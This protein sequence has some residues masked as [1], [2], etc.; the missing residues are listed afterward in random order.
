M[1]VNGIKYDIVLKKLKAGA[2]KRYTQP[3]TEKGVIGAAAFHDCS[4]YW[5]LNENYYI[6]FKVKDKYIN[7][8]LV[9]INPKKKTQDVAKW[10]F[11]NFA[12]YGV[13]DIDLKDIKKTKKKKKKNDIKGVTNHN[14]RRLKAFFAAHWNDMIGDGDLNKS[15]KRIELVLHQRKIVQTSTEFK[16]NGEFIEPIYEN[17]PRIKREPN[18]YGNYGLS[19][20]LRSGSNTNTNNSNLRSKIRKRKRKRDQCQYSQNLNV[21]R[22]HRRITNNCINSYSSSPRKRQRLQSVVKNEDISSESSDDDDDIDLDI[23]SSSN[24]NSNCNSMS[25]IPPSI[26]PMMNIAMPQT[27]NPTVYSNPSFLNGLTQAIPWDELKRLRVE[28]KTLAVKNNDLERANCKL[29]QDLNKLS[30]NYQNLESEMFNNKHVQSQTEQKV[31]KMVD[32]KIEKD[33]QNYDLE[34]KYQVLQEENNR[35]QKELHRKRNLEIELKKKQK[36]LNDMEQHI[37]KSIEDSL[38][39]ALKGNVNGKVIDLITGSTLSAGP[40]NSYLLKKEDEDIIKLKQ[41]NDALRE[42][43]KSMIHDKERMDAYYRNQYI[44]LYNSLCNKFIQDI[45]NQFGQIKGEIDR[46]KQENADLQFQRDFWYSIIG[47]CNPKMIELLMS[48]HDIVANNGNDTNTIIN[49]INNHINNNNENFS[50]TNSQN[51]LLTNSSPQQTQLFDIM[52]VGKE[53]INN[54]NT[55]NGH[56]QNETQM[57][58]N[59]VEN[60]KDNNKLTPIPANSMTMNNG[61]FPIQAPLPLPANSWQAIQTTKPSKKQNQGLNLNLNPNNSHQNGL[62][63]LSQPNITNNVISAQILDLNSK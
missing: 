9:P 45:A 52:N 24:S 20:C 13:E 8:G 29:R 32:I 51:T 27:V 39:P 62:I 48:T 30:R 4:V 41:E 11:Q 53:N 22:H 63:Q 7:Q 15:L 43:N 47:Q 57:S 58:S 2:I 28:N 3:A 49:I 40:C 59:S 19:Q 46:L 44:N 37:E 12:V 16:I 42:E 17:G 14:G 10:W 31:N 5:Q 34:K 36:E 1:T 18:N 61:P 33:S 23:T 38:N 55:N 6:E 54:I 26:T 50:E 35:L 25:M 21:D 56:N 60:V